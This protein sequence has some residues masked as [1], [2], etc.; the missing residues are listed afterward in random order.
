MDDPTGGIAGGVDVDGAGVFPDG[1]DDFI[2]AQIPA[3]MLQALAHEADIGA[4]GAHGIFDIR[5]V[6]TDDQ[7]VTAVPQGHLRGQSNTHHARA[8]HGNAIRIQI[9]IVDPVQVGLYGIA[10]LDAAAGVGVEGI[11][12]IDGAFRR[13]ADELRCDQ[14]AFS[15][16]Q[17]YDRRV[18]EAGQGN[19]GD[20]AW[21]QVLDLGA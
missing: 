2:G 19:L 4:G 18:G 13:L 20:A 5:P 6:R 1:R 16:P 11:A 14:V 21:L 9:H 8:R 3:T 15:D 10:Q 17:G 12:F 7:R